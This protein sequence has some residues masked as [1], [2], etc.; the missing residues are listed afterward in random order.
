MSFKDIHLVVAT[1]NRRAGLRFALKV[2]PDQ[3]PSWCLV[4]DDPKVIRA[5]PDK[6]HCVSYWTA[7]HPSL[8]ELAWRERQ[9]EGKSSGVSA[10]MMDWIA[11]W[12]REHEAREHAI[13]FAHLKNGVAAL[14]AERAATDVAP[15]ETVIKA[16]AVGKST[17]TVGGSKW[18]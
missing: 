15:V 10:A 14:E 13:A 18:R 16:Q 5:I 7:R 8:A 6:M 2:Y 1:D 3:C 12:I 11:G 17:Q 4:T 9:A